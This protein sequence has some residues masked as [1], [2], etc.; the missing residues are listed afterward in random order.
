MGEGRNGGQSLWLSE[1]PVHMLG[2]VRALLRVK[3]EEEVK[4]CGDFDWRPTVCQVSF[5]P[6]VISYPR[7]AQLQMGKLRHRVPRLAIGGLQQVKLSWL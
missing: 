1:L 5:T 3:W 6:H 4:G 2:T 7:P